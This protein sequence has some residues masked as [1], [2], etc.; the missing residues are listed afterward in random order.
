MQVGVR[1]SLADES[2]MEVID[3][4][5]ISV[6]RNLDVV[7]ADITTAVRIAEDGRRG[8]LGERLQFARILAI[9]GQAREHAVRSA[10]S[11]GVHGF[12]LTSSPVRELV[13]GLRALSRGINYLCDP[14][15]Q[16]LSQVAQRDMLTIREEEVLRLLAKGRGNKSIARELD[17]AVGTAKAHVKSILSKLDASSRAEAASSAT[18][19]GLV[20]VPDSLLRPRE[21]YPSAAAWS[22]R[23]TKGERARW[24]LPRRNDPAAAQMTR[25]AS[26]NELKDDLLSLS[27]TLQRDA[28]AIVFLNVVLQQL[29]LLAA[30]V[31]TMLLAGQPRRSPRVGR[32]DPGGRCGRVLAG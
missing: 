23:A 32:K 31:P 21:P 17:I 25:V 9:T 19:R 30:A 5:L 27:Q 16:Q 18:Q 11:Q 24:M 14:V 13:A 2:D 26:R 28:V 7:V 8:A 1:A 3:A 15:A 29:G 4:D 10:R 12:V 22:A 20:D 6:H